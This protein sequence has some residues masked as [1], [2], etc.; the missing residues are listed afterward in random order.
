MR[1]GTFFLVGVLLGE[2]GGNVFLTLSVC[3]SWKRQF[4]FKDQDPLE[5]ESKAVGETHT[6]QEV[7][8]PTDL[9][10]AQK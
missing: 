9:C 4:G 8:V 5:D 2:E 7:A 6:P 3:S 1:P 10:M